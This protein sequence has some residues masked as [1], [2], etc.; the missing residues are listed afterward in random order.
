M[1]VRT[2]T[3]LHALHEATKT[4]KARVSPPVGQATP[5]LVTDLGYLIDSAADSQILALAEEEVT[6]ADTT[7]GE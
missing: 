1:F 2:R 7:A 6:L 4:N 5:G 3:N